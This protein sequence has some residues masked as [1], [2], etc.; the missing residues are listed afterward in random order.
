MWRLNPHARTEF[1]HLGMWA[2][3]LLGCVCICCAAA[4]FGFLT[5]RGWG[6]WLGVAMLALNLT[7]DLLSGLSGLEPRAWVGVP[8]AG[9]LLWYLTSR[10]VRS[11][12]GV[13]ALAGKRP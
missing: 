13:V 12:F 5:G 11:F 8:I 9:L 6:Y 4:S 10:N 7:G 2:P 1:A 3:M